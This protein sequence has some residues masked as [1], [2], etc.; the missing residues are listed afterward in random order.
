MADKTLEYL[1]KLNA[2]GAVSGLRSAADASSMLAAAE[3]AEATAARESAR[4]QEEAARAAAGAA[5]QKRR[6]TILLENL[7]VR[8]DTSGAAALSYQRQIANIEELRR[9][10]GDEALAQRALAATSK[11]YAGTLHVST[12]A[13]TAHAQAM[14]KAGVSAGSLRHGVSSLGSQFADVG[15]QMAMGMNPMMIAVQQGPQI[16]GALGMMGSAGVAAGATMAALSVVAGAGYV[17]WKTYNVEADR[18][19]DALRIF[20]A[21]ADGVKSVTADATS[22]TIAFA[23]ATGQ[24]TEEQGKLAAA[25]VKAQADT[26]ASIQPYADAI[27]ASQDSMRGAHGLYTQWVDD[28]SSV[29]NQL[30]AATKYMGFLGWAPAGVAKAFDAVTTSSADLNIEIGNQAAAQ[31]LLILAQSDAIKVTNALIGAE[32]DAKKKKEDLAEATR[33]AAEASRK[34][35]EQL[36]QEEA[37]WDRWIA[38]AAGA[39]RATLALAAADRALRAGRAGSREEQ[40]SILAV[41]ASSGEWRAIARQARMA[42]AE[43]ARDAREEW[44]QI[45]ADVGKMMAEQFNEDV[46]VKQK[47]G[48]F[49][50]GNLSWFNAAQDP[51]ALMQKAAGD[52]KAGGWIMAIVN[53]VANFDQTVDKFA[54]Y[55]EKIMGQIGNFWGTIGSNLK[56]KLVDGSQQAMDG[57]ANFFQGFAD[58]FDDIIQGLFEAI[59]QIFGMLLKLIFQQLPNAVWSIVKAVFDMSMWASAIKALVQGF[60]TAIGD[61]IKSIV[62]GK[63]NQGI[64]VKGGGWW[65]RAGDAVGDAVLGKN[66][67]GVLSDIWRGPQGEGGI[68]GLVGSFDSGGYIPRTGLAMVHRGEYVSTSA[69]TSRGQRRTSDGTG[70]GV[71]NVNIG[72]VYGGREAARQIADLLREHMGSNGQRLTIQ[73][74]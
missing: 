34:H 41:P 14:T 44:I 17:A 37:A 4:A 61:A 45:A 67:Q 64:F 53:A 20:G 31:S 30:E 46:E 62:Q 15:V 5:E 42:G 26:T 10:T 39:E 35:A 52:S 28:I 21:A 72:P 25:T 29:N 19:A 33:L 11:E 63:D 71:T 65:D 13:T 51:Q 1:L 16:A 27:K 40:E 58:N 36:R 12:A 59:P 74:A 73:G 55:H 47:G 48:M 54:D 9:V 69:E 38:T 50:E 32:A 66:R 7:A 23:V 22:K 57:V 43:S 18:A 49:S 24:L 68:K 6:A 56:S 60:V 2:S 8:G 70:A 3:R